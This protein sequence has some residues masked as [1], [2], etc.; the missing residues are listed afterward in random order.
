MCSQSASA[1]D[2]NLLGFTDRHGVR[3]R[4]AP[5]L[6]GGACSFPAEERRNF[7]EKRLLHQASVKD[8][9]IVLIAGPASNLCFAG[10][11]WAYHFL[12]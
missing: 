2:L 7:I 5:L 3:W 11:V 10:L 6:A 12:P 9:A 4:L 8:R 1:L